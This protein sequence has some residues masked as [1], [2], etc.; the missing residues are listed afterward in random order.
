ML[1]LGTIRKNAREEIRF[2]VENFK[3]HEIINLRVW[4]RDAAGEYRPGKQGLAFRLEKLGDVLAVLKAAM[5]GAGHE[6]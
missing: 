4:Y 2:T 6:H 5:K 1:T 3:G